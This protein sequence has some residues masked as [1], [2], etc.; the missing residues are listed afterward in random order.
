MGHSILKSYYYTSLQSQ[1]WNYIFLAVKKS[2]KFPRESSKSS[3]AEHMLWVFGVHS[4]VFSHKKIL[5]NYKSFFEVQAWL[6][7]LNKSA[8]KSGKSTC[9]FLYDTTHS[10]EHN[11]MHELYIFHKHKKHTFGILESSFFQTTSLPYKTQEGIVG[12]FKCISIWQLSQPHA[13][14][15]WKPHWSRIAGI[16]KF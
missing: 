3:F 4:L 2:Q 12:D 11:I 13:R 15:S 5:G 8:M 6:R 1:A 14:L 10:Q 16:S 7:N 9:N